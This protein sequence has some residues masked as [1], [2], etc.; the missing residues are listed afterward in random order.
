ML[1]HIEKKLKRFFS[2][3][4]KRDKIREEQKKKIWKKIKKT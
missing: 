4:K 1:G 3:F 2:I